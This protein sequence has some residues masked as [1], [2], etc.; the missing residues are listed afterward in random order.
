[1]SQQEP[2][3]T[4]SQSASNKEAAIIGQG[5]FRYQARPD[6]AQLPAGWS[7]VEVVGVATDSADRVYVFNRGQHPLV[8]FDRDGRF[9]R[10]WGEGQFVRPHGITIG[11]DD[12]IYCVDDVGHAVYKFTAEGQML[13]KLGSGQPSDTGARGFDYRTIARAA[14]P[15]NCPTN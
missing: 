9:L 3:M 1:A 8:V 14:G 13:A 10:S 15:F 5:A 11:P 2:S 6:W 4:P 7:F 12:A